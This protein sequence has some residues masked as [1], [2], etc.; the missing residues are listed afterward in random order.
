M[1]SPPSRA[2]TL[3]D[4]VATSTYTSNPALVVDYAQAQSLSVITSNTG[5]SRHTVEGSLAD[6]FS[7]AIPNDSWS[8]VTVLTADGVYTVD[9]GLRW[10]RVARSAIDSQ[11]TVRFSGA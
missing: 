2:I 11:T 1:Y 7:T 6:G 3:L 4:S 5:L 10:L 9:P 8:V